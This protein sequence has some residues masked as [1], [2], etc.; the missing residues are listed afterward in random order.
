MLKKK[1]TWIILGIVAIVLIGGGIFAATRT[2]NSQTGTSQL[3]A[4]A[5]QATVVQ[6]TLVTSVDSTGSLMPESEV[7]LSFNTSGTVAEV[8]AVVGDQVKKGD[9]LATLNSTDLQHKVTQAEQSYLLQ[10]ITFSNTLEPE[11]SDVAVAEASYASALASYN[12]AQTDYANLA[13]KESVQC[14]QLSSAKTNL[15][16]AQTAYDR[17]ADDHQASQYLNGDWGPYQ[18]IVNDLSNAQAAYDQAVS[19]CNI[20]KLNLNDSAL[21]SAKAQLLNA[22]TTLDN[23]TSPRTEKQIQAAAALEQARLSLEQAKR[24][25]AEAT[26]TAPFDGLITAV[27]ITAGGAGGANAITLADI[28]QLHVDVLVDET[29]IADVKIGQEAQVTLDALNGITLTGT[30]ANIDPTGTVSN[31]VVNYSVRVDLD[32]TEAALKL[33]MTANASLIGEKAE[34]VLAV[35]TKAIRTGRAMN[36]A[37]TQSGQTVSTTASSL[38][39]VLQDGQPR[40]VPVTVG[41][42]AGDLTEVS[43]DLQ[44]GDE[45]LIV[46]T[47]S[48]NSDT[49]DFGPP[50]GVPDGV[51]GPPPD[52]GMG[53]PPPGG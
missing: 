44:A 16:R 17:I 50:D 41:M 21:R 8:K 45:V 2:A 28:S 32:P 12:A 15:D 38:V 49:Q 52:G 30:V 26:L 25:L 19:N 37:S 46:T 42:T 29:E 14:A 34:N 40:P 39:M 20:T 36:Q 23:L 43:G 31:G 11:A 1:R 33:D 3:L 35:P 24:N 27:N 47:T 53:G 4:N 7:A 13:T 51:G 10:Q 48:T 18:N 6:M 5:Q 22:K 9:V